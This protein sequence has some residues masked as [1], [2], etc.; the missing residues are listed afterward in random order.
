MSPRVLCILKFDSS[1]VLEFD[2]VERAGWSLAPRLGECWSLA[3]RMSWSVRGAWD[4]EREREIECMYAETEGSR[5]REVE[6]EKVA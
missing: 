1:Y 3:S 2:S 4:R 5:A 6:S